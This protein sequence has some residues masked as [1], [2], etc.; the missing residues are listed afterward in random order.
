MTVGFTRL[1]AH[2]VP[3][4]QA[5]PAEQVASFVFGSSGQ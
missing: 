5:L 1:L 4:W 3:G 2:A